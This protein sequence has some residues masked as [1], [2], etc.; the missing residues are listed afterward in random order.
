MDLTLREVDL[1]D[2]SVQNTPDGA[3]VG[4]AAEYHESRYVRVLV[5]SLRLGCQTTA[6]SQVGCIGWIRLYDQVCAPSLGINQAPPLPTPA[7]SAGAG[8][9][10]PR[11]RREFKGAWSFRLV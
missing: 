1:N 2:S 5:H 8:G 9:P 3:V 6:N 10:E 4:F 11:V 7:R